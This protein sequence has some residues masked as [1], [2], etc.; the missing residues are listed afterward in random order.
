MT[1]PVDTERYTI[2]MMALGFA[3]GLV[4]RMARFHGGT[5]FDEDVA[6][7]RERMQR[8]MELNDEAQPPTT[9]DQTKTRRGN[10]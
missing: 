8:V 2:A 6:W 9:L 4:I 7:L 10:S 1:H 5:E 3:Y